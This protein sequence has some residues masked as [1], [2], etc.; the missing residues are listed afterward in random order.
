MNTNDTAFFTIQV[1]GGSKVVSLQPN[2]ISFI[3]GY[4][5]D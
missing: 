1:A 4:L 2:G 5:L 3:Y